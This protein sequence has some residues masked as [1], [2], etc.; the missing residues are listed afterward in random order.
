MIR[1]PPRS[2]RT[3]T[4]FPY[5]TLFRSGGAAG[6]VGRNHVAVA[7]PSA[8]HFD[9]LVGDHALYARIA[10]RVAAGESYYT[11]AAAE[12]RSGHYPLRPFVTVRLP[13]LAHIVPPLG[14]QKTNLPFFLVGGGAVFPWYRRFGTDARVPPHP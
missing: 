14:E 8:A 5:T 10:Q 12:H 13:T 6:G 1:R 7:S 3:D 2:T 9:G 4:L 11:A